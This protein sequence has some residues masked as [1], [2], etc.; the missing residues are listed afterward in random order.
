MTFVSTYRRCLPWVV[1]VLALGMAATIPDTRTR[2]LMRNTLLYAGSCTAMATVVG[3]TI[4]LLLFR[5]QRSCRV[6]LAMLLT[7]MVLP[8]YLQVSGW[9]A[10][11]GF[12]GWWTRMM[13]SP[14]ATPWIKGWTGAVAIQSIVAI[15]WVTM[16][17]GLGLNRIPR[18]LEQ[19]A[20][21][22]ASDRQVIWHITL[23]LA[24]PS[25]VAASLLTFVMSANEITITDVYH[26]RTFAE[27]IYTGFALGDE[28]IAAQLRALPGSLLLGA[29]ALAAML[30]CRELVRPGTWQ[31]SG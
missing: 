9:D 20:S 31:S 7:L 14:G 21:L 3:T 29:F 8:A 22:S 18:E 28:L 4:A 19:C 25:I 23:P 16:I 26:I 12:Q 5:C 10:G 17:V 30:S 11:F 27:E 1:L 15:P 24:Q 2:G 6:Q 13:A